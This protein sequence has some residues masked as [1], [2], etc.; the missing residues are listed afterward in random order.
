[1]AWGPQFVTAVT[2]IIGMGGS[3]WHGLIIRMD[4]QICESCQ[5][6]SPRSILPTVLLHRQSIIRQPT[7]TVSASQGVKHALL[8]GRGNFVTSLFSLQITLLC[9]LL[10]CGTSHVS[11][12]TGCRAGFLLQLFTLRGNFQHEVQRGSS[13]QKPG[14]TDLAIHPLL[15]H[16]FQGYPQPQIDR[17]GYPVSLVVAPETDR[18]SVEKQIP[19]KRR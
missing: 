19:V 4:L 8:R 7:P 16:D 13:Q 3:G 15:R 18:G 1:M 14:T 12:A 5:A 9:V 17:P 10:A 2:I 11:L 6:P